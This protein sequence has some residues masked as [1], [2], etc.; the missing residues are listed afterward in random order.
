MRREQVAVI[1]Q[2][3]P[4]GRSGTRFTLRPGPQN[5]GR[6]R[7]SGLLFSAGLAVLLI[8]ASAYVLDPR[9]LPIRHV[10]VDGEFRHLSTA[11]LQLRAEDVVRGGFFDVNVEGIRAAL[12]QEPWV[13]E[14]TV[15]RIWPDELGLQVQEQVAVARWGGN[16]LLNEQGQLFKPSAGTL[17]PN[18]PS[19]NGP[20]GTHAEALARFRTLQHA[21]GG[22]QLIVAQLRL[23][24]RRSWSFALAD[25][26]SV[27]LGRRDFDARVGRFAAIVP[28]FMAGD[29]NRIE[30]ID[31]RYTNGFAVRW[32]PSS[33][34]VT[35]AAP[36][37]HGQTES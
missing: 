35:S 9:T 25:G 36:E 24:A 4:A 8:V 20:A 32:K 34:G 19:L 21:L 37:N 1:G 6:G 10:R 12:L 7:G 29:L 11:A 30:V 2:A 27:D 15:R 23:S 26:P 13:R 14:V 3:R 16:Q 22:R 28:T 5:P 33:A 17:P 18:L 31:M